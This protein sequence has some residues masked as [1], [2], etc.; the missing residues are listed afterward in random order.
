MKSNEEG[1][2][3]IEEREGRDDSDLLLVITV[4]ASAIVR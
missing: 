4:A 2:E 1:N 3:I